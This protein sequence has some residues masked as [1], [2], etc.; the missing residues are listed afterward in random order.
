MKQVCKVI[1]GGNLNL[2]LAE[3]QPQGFSNDLPFVAHTFI[4]LQEASY[5]SD[6]DLSAV[7]TRP[8]ALKLVE[9]VEEGLRAWRHVR[10]RDEATVFLTALLLAKKW[11]R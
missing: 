6:H 2:V 9:R 10:A 7:S 4:E 5:L 1:V 3:L 11:A 8:I